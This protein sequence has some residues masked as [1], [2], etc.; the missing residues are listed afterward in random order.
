MSARLEATFERLRAQGR[1]GLV[2]YV[3]A[4]DPDLPRSAAVVE[5][6]EA[7]GADVIELGVPF[8]DPLADGPVIQRAAERAL[9]AGATLDRVLALAADLRPRLT[10]PLV[11]FTYANPVLRMGLERFA[12]RAADG[13]TRT[14]RP[15]HTRYDG[16]VAFALAT[17]P[18]PDDPAANV[19][20]LGYLATEAVAAA[21]RA[22]VA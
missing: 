2:T 19:D 16:D 20:L 17:P 1:A 22:A 13:V 18:G 5:A 11:L 9:R 12:A 15:A 3:T 21:V 7:G 8:S 10:I 6:L 4:G 14:V